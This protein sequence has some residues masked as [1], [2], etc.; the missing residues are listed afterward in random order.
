[1]RKKIKKINAAI[2]IIGNEILSGRTQD[3]NITFIS[4]WLNSK[5][6]IS[7]NQIISEFEEE[8]I[9]T[10]R[11]WKPMHMQPI[12]KN[13]HAFPASKPS[14]LCMDVILLS[15]R[16]LNCIRGNRSANST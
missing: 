9:E 2:L 15:G 3:K 8:Q 1:M 6:G 11:L 14:R 13:N 5:C 16:F 7:V 12:F 4:N 10:R